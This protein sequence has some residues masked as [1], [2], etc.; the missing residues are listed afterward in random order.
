MTALEFACDAPMPSATVEVARRLVSDDGSACYLLVDPALLDTD[1]FYTLV[2]RRG[3]ICH[4]T[5][6]T[7]SLAAFGELAPQLLQF[8]GGELQIRSAVDELLRV[9]DDAPALS[10]LVCRG[11]LA[12]L[13]ALLAYLAKVKTHER[14]AAIHCRFA[15]T[16]VLPVLLS[17]LSP[18]QRSRV[19][20][21]IQHW[22]WF[23]RTGA[24]AGWSES[25]ADATVEED[26][27]DDHLHLNLEQFHAMQRAGEADAMFTI[28]L[29]KTSELVPASGRGRFHA[30]LERYLANAS[31]LKVSG[32]ED[33]LQFLVMSLT[34]G[35]RFYAHPALVDTWADVAAGRLSFIQAQA[36]WSDDLWREL[37]PLVQEAP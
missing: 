30:E 34:C 18:V 22:G 6:S 7:S 28:L 10:W 20:Q 17:V 1:R 19:S 16:R 21:A 2:R 27:R 25:V 31:R 33:R 15:D 13:R 37:D 35:E 4:N 29:D 8:N 5:L 3:W 11:W 26:G 12:E 14:K 23:D 36:T 24:I 32:A 9:A